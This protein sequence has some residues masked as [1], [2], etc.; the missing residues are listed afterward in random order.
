MRPPLSTSSGR[1]FCSGSAHETKLLKR[2]HAI[3]QS[4]LL[5]DLA[6]LKAKHGRSGE[7][8]LPAGCRRQRS[9]EK[10]TEGWPGMRTAA[11]WRAGRV[12]KGMS[13]AASSSTTVR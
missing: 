6:I 8:H 9:D 13:G 3:I 1:I 10:F 7:V 2:G 12:L 4:D 5:C 11:P